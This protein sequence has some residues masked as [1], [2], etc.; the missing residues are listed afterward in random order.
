MT[1]SSAAALYLSAAAQTVW[2][3]VAARWGLAFRNSQYGP[4]RA[5]LTRF[6]S[7]SPTLIYFFFIKKP[8]LR[9]I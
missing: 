1:F 4:G 8:S 3:F 5:L 2:Q 6:D 7:I 9:F